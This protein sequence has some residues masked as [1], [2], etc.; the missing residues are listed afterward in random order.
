LP[1]IWKRASSHLRDAIDP[2]ATV[3]EVKKR[4]RANGWTVVEHGSTR[5]QASA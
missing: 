3:V 2:R 4:L 1:S 5:I